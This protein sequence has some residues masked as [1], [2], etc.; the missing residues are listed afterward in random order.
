MGVPGIS[1]EDIKLKKPLQITHPILTCIYIYIYFFLG[2]VGFW[3]EGKKPSNQMV[4]T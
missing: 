2:G 3:G 1:L 4:A